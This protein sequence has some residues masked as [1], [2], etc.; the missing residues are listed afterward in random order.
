MGVD[1]SILVLVHVEPIPEAGFLKTYR[2]V[3][4]KRPG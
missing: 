3:S 2:Y 1:L 4:T